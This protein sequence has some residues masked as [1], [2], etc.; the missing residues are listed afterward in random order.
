LKNNKRQ[1]VVIIHGI[2]EQR[3]MKTLRGFVSSLLNYEKSDHAELNPGHETKVSDRNFWTKPDRISNSYELRKITAKGEKNVRSTTHFYEY[4][5]ASN[6]RDNKTKH[7]WQWLTPIIWRGTTNTDLRVATLTYFLRLLI[8]A[9]P[10]LCLFIL[11]SL[12]NKLEFKWWFLFLGLP[13]S[14]LPIR[15]FIKSYAAD[16][17]R[18]FQPNNDNIAQ[19]EVIRQNGINLIR[20]LHKTEDYDRIVLVGHSLGS[21]IAYDIITY[22][23]IEFNKSINLNQGHNLVYR[24]K[25]KWG[26]SFGN[27]NEESEQL[28]NLNDITYLINQYDSEG[29]KIEL[30]DFHIKVQANKTHINKGVETDGRDEHKDS[31]EHLRKDFQNAQSEMWKAVS[32]KRKGWLISDLVTIGSPLTHANLLMAD[33]EFDF[34][35]RID[36]REYPTCPPQVDD[37]KFTYGNDDGDKFIHHATPF[38]A[39]RWTNLYYQSDLVGGKVAKRFGNAI[40]DRKIN[41]PSWF[42]NYFPNTH[43]AYWA[44][45]SNPDNIKTISEYESIRQLYKAIRLN[46]I[47]EGL[48]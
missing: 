38:V 1:A 7:V 3:P 36:E 29:Q 14:I 30:G 27:V 16:A 44:K 40:V 34:K 23:W 24:S 19:R 43:N 32:H 6:M 47:E 46:D 13:F 42:R 45:N 21:V 5:W 31:I 33:S 2:G 11:L 28:K 39:T 35:L 10:I 17:A 8:I 20:A 12:D 41:H 48:Y 9:Y 22:L 18:Y 25:C 37:G 4:H 26:I 15:K